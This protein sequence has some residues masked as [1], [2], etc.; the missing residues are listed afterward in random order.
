MPIDSQGVRA[1]IVMDAGSTI[2]RMNLGR[3]YE[4]YF[5]SAAQHLSRNI[6]QMLNIPEGLGFSETM[7]RLRKVDP[8]IQDQAYQHVLGFY[9]LLSEE[10]YLFFRDGVSLEDRVEHLGDIIRE[11]IYLFYPIN[12]QRDIEQA[13]MDVE[14]SPYKPP[15]D[16][17]SYVGNSGQR[18]LTEQPFRIG[19][20]YMMLLEKITDD[21]SSV[22]SGKL[23]HFG[24]LSPTTKSEKYAYP[25]R[26]SPVRTIGETEGRIFAGYCGREAIAEMMDRSNNPTTH[27]HIVWQLLSADK[28]TNIEK[29]VDRQAIPLGASKPLQLVRHISMTSGWQPVYVPPETNKR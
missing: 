3:L 15:Y 24:I 2:N 14:M 27:R 9:Q 12:N 23:Q 18:V 28:P 25:F 11:G 6:R 19:P 17:V 16:R 5:G 10:Q 1:D 26:N 7:K 8:M 13:V 29:I 4:Q 20:L 22:S 21:W